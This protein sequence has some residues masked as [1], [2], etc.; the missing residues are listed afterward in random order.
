[1]SKSTGSWIARSS[2]LLYEAGV[3][4]LI[5][6]HARNLVVSTLM[7]AVGLEALESDPVELSVP[8]LVSSGYLVTAFGVTLLLINLGQGLH[9]LAKARM[10]YLYQGL[11]VVAYVVLFWRVT[12]LVLL[13]R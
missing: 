13:F 9:Q 10:N 7:L 2:H 6:E 3:A 11:L 4:R 8:Y 5:F 12:H 1:M